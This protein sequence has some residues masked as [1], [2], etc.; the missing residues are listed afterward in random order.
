MDRLTSPALAMTAPGSPSVNGYVPAAYDVLP[1]PQAGPV[2]DYARLI[3]QGGALGGRPGDAGGP[4]GP[5][6]EDSPPWRQM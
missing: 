1:L 6:G 5:A 4:W 3:A 2:A